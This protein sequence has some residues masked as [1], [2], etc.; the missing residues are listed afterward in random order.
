MPDSDPF[1]HLTW[2]GRGS[3]HADPAKLKLDSV[4]GAT[5]L[6]DE[7]IP[8][9]LIKA[10]N[11]AAMRSLL[12]Q[13]EGRIDLIYVDPPFLT[14]RAY[15]ARVGRGEDSRHPDEWKTATGYTDEWD[16]GGQYL[17]ALLPRLEMMHRLLSASGSLYVHLDWH[18]SAYVRVLLDEIFG[19]DRFLNEIVWVY[20]GPSPIRTAF[21]RKHDTI[22]VYTKSKDYKFNADA[23][24]VP[25]SDSTVKTF[26]SSSKAGFG[27]KPDLERGKVPEDWWYFPVVARLHSERTGY[28]TQKPEALIERIILAATDPGDIV[29]DFYSGSGTTPVVAARH[30][31]QWIACDAVPLAIWTTARRLLL[32]H[33]DPAFSLHKDQAIKSTA[34]DLKWS[35]DR[36][37]GTIRLLALEESDAPQDFPGNIAFWEIDPNY[38]GLVFR[39]RYRAVRELG[40][41]VLPLELSVPAYVEGKSTL[42]VR[43]IDTVGRVGLGTSDG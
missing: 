22:L 16:D 30:D 29:A 33:P 10:E 20:H 6:A 18:A 25:Y 41:D 40:S 3:V 23:V 19:P 8:G 39:G 14:G 5:G 26:A 38:D 13:Y 42:A 7:P 31:R 36:A 12:E 4:F 37:N 32:N 1:A 34:L 21:N 24:R 11:L 2:P 9:Q 27:K 43:A 28:P 17:S 35:F 15:R